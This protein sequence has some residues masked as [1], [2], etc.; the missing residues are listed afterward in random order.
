M[1]I[2]GL[3]GKKL[4]HS[5]SKGYFESKF[6]TMGIKAKYLNFE[7]EDIQQL[8]TVISNQPE[9]KGLN[10]TIPYKKAVLD[11]VDI[12][13]PIAERIGSVN[14]LKINRSGADISISA[15]NTDVVGFKQSLSQLIAEKKPEAALILGTGGASNAV[16]FVL[17][18]LNI[19]HLF[20]SRFPRSADQLSYAS[21]TA[22]ILKS[23]PLIINTTPLGMYPKK[24]EAP[25]IPYASLDSEH[26]LYD[27]IYNPAE[28]LFLKQGRK[29]ACKTM[30]GQRMLE[31]QAEASWKI[32]VG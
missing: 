21:L 6:K 11:F 10:V 26:L 22:E 24:D 7:L 5:F 9:L 2:Y 14:T 31:L 16:S 18:E 13:D 32:W 3:I 12:I 15:Y 25:D 29:S 20:V 28:T 30:N 27:L 8:Q 4:S 17:N 1:E 23:H 19:T